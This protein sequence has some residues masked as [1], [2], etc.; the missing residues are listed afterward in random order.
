[1][2]KESKVHLRLL[3]L[4][5]APLMLEWMHDDSVVHYMKANFR[6]KTLSDCNAFIEETIAEANK[7]KNVHFLHLAVADENETY[8]GTV[9]LKHIKDNTAEFAITMRKEAMGKGYAKEGMKQIIDYGLNNL[10]LSMI[11]WYVNA[12][13]ISA[14][15]FYD[16]NGYQRVN[17][18]DLLN[19]IGGCT[20][21]EN[22]QLIWYQEKKISLE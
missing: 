19:E 20:G 11:Y 22:V 14:I 17:Y 6:D 2:Y 5:D 15:R 3:N 18:Q 1:M 9:S 10:N 12:E 7:G 13:N 16:K 8:M 21:T 4:S